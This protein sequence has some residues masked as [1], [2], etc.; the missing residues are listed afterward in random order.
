[1]YF[2]FY[3]YYR[4]LLPYHHHLYHHHHQAAEEEEELEF[5]A[6]MEP[7]MVGLGQACMHAREKSKRRHGE[8]QEAKQKSVSSMP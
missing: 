4:L 2:Y 8:R 5:N 3:Y 1:M 7:A 6:L